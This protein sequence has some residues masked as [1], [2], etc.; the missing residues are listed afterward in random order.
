MRRP[1]GFSFSCSRVCPGDSLKLVDTQGDGFWIDPFQGAVVLTDSPFGSQ[2][3][4]E[5]QAASRHRAIDGV[6][7]GG[8]R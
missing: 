2:G 4:Q 7:S 8:R 6:C 3:K 5:C 1:Y